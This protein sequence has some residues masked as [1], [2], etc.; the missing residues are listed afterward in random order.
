M[1][2]KQSLGRQSRKGER[3]KEI[4]GLNGEEKKEL[5]AFPVWNGWKNESEEC[6]GTAM[7]QMKIPKIISQTGAGQDFYRDIICALAVFYSAHF[8][9]F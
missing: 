6:H 5:F 4:S 7:A 9:G 2:R 8:Y 1:K 3:E